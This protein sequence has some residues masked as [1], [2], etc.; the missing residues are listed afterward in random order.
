[1]ILLIFSVVIFLANIVF[2]MLV[3]VICS[4]NFHCIHLEKSSALFAAEIF[5]HYSDPAGDS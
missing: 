2:L 3:Q 1:M 4:S 5:S